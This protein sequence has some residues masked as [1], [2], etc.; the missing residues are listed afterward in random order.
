MKKLILLMLLL[1]AHSLIELRA[2]T[3]F[4]KE[5]SGTKTE[6]LLSNIKMISFSSGSIE[7]KKTDGNFD[8]YDLSELRYLNFTDI[9]TGIIPIASKTKVIEIQVYP[10]PVA[11]ILNIQFPKFKNQSGV[12]EILSIEGKVFYTQMINS[13]SNIYQI[14]ISS[15]SKGLYLCRINNGITIETIKFLKQ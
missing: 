14:N 5:T 8:V 12:I 15:L 10:N 9:S 11:D 2:Q 4:A 7:I 13:Q 3:M 1:L 6:Y